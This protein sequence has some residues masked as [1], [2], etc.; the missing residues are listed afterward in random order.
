MRRRETSERQQK[1]LDLLFEAGN[2]SIDDLARRFDVSR[3]TIHRDADAL[4]GRGL[5]NKIHGGLTV[6]NRA[7][8]T[9][10]VSY[11]QGKALSLKQAIITDAVAHVRPEQVLILDDSTTVAEMLPLLPALAPLT[12][13]T[14]AM[15]VIQALAPYPGLKLICVGGE[16]SPSRDAFFGLI[17]ER[18]AQALRADTMFLSTS[19]VNGVTAYQ[20]DQDVVMVKRALMSIA[21]RSI[22]LADSTKFRKAGLHQLAELQEFDEVLADGDLGDA[23]RKRLIDNGV[24]LK[25][26]S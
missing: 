20:N 25:I 1:I 22:L 17:S 24:N 4:V 9:R 8:A 7:T 23:Q 15:G 18:G 12:I 11:R 21:D 3:M 2:A 5:I 6:R 10:S 16:Y 19:V 14:N 13:I 26:C